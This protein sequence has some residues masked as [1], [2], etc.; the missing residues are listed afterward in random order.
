[1]SAPETPLLTTPPIPDHDSGH[2]VEGGAAAAVLRGFFGSD[3]A[4]FELCSYMMPPG[5]TCTDPSP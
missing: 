4:H 3:R 1:M 2:A 5:E